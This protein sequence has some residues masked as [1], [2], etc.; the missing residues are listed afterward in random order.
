MKQMHYLTEIIDLFR[1]LIPILILLQKCIVIIIIII[2]IPL[3]ELKGEI[4]LCS[5]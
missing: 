3:N 2:V 4:L 5:V 1:L